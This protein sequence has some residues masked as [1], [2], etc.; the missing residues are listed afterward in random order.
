M[1]AIIISILEFIIILLGLILTWPQ[2]KKHLLFLPRPLIRI[3]YQELDNGFL[4]LFENIGN[5]P[6]EYFT[7]EIRAK[8]GIFSFKDK[9][10]DFEL[11]VP[12]GAGTFASISGENILPKQK[13]SVSLI[14]E[15][16]KTN[17]EAP[18]ITSD[19]R[20]IFAGTFS[21]SS[22]PLEKYAKEDTTMTGEKKDISLQDV[23]DEL[24]R[25][26]GESKRQIYF[27]GFIF[28][29]TVAMAGAS[30]WAPTLSD[31]WQRFNSVG[32]FI[33]GACFAI[34][35][36]RKANKHKKFDK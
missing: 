33:M 25:T 26:Q 3:S 13:G 17:L 9:S 6:A 1:A 16:K 10:S 18:K 36:V 21:I 34:W 35:C 11:S 27:G 30:M 2:V 20:Y 32:I 7:A 5:A 29:L 4:I 28:G 23:Y 19:S 22:G 31:Y 24:K 15:N 12:S 8:G 14:F